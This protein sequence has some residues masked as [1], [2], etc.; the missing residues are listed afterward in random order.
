MD[1]MIHF[2]ATL[3]VQIIFKATQPERRDK[4]PYANGY[5]NSHTVWD[6]K[7]EFI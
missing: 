6:H 5:N 1:H 7:K 2:L 3:S 4:M